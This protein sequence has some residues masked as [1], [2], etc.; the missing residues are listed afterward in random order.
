M[1]L[2]SGPIGRPMDR[3]GAGRRDRVPLSR[4]PYLRQTF[5]VQGKSPIGAR[6]Y[7]T[8]Q[9]LYEMYL[10]GQ[11]LGEDLLTP[12]LDGLSQARQQYQ[13][14][15]VTGLLHTG[16]NVVGAVLGDGWYCGHVAWR[17]RQNYGDRP[18]LLAQLEIIFED[19]SLTTVASDA[20][21]EYA[22]GPILE[23]DLLMG[24]SYDA[25]LEARHWSGPGSAGWKWIPV[26]TFNDAG[27]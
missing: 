10:N 7:I 21:W 6:L 4:R 16:E 27:N 8:A 2:L 24:E 19:G 15:D 17:E 26:E 14:Y 20:T 23:A 3:G 22:F 11:R 9:G 1:G 18:K 25:R 13:T 12:G 5:H